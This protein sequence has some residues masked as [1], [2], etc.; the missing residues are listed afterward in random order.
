LAPKEAANQTRQNLRAAILLFVCWQPYVACGAVPEH[1]P[2]FVSGEGGYHTYRIPAIVMNSRGVALA[3][4]EGRK[5]SARDDGDIDLLVRRS[6]DEGRTWQPVQVVHEEGGDQPITIGNPSPIL[7]ADGTIQLLFCRDNR[8][9][10]CTQ[11]T[12]DG[13][14]FSK[15]R[16][17]TESLRLFEFSF[18]RLGT[19]PGHG[20]QTSTGRLLA[21]LWLNDKIGKDYRSGVAY[22]DDG[23][24]TW[25]AGG[26]VAADVQGLNECS[27][28]ELPGG[29]LLLNMR[30]RQAK[31][32]AVATSADGGLSWSLPRLAEELVDP[33]C[34]GS[35]LR[36][37]GGDL[38]RLIFSN[39]ADSKRLRLTVRLSADAGRTWSA[40]QLLHAGPSAYS[41]LAVA[42]DGTLLCVYE[43]GR[44]SPYEQIALTRWKPE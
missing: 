39:A 26:L 36:L 24:T 10:F 23:G 34:Q 11:T 33:Q 40:G 38:G 20:I 29:R 27:V 1:V 32:R 8:R 28:A 42:A 16:E 4:C 30:N 12:D 25:R 9:A 44:K 35:L 13:R 14:T 3:F 21:P 43:R 5:A 17:I 18:I 7:A 41:D 19:G 37:P 22:S 6:L 15:P 2:L 31:C